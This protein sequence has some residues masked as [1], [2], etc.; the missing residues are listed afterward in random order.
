MLFKILIFT[1][2]HLSKSCIKVREEAVGT[3]LWE[4]NAGLFQALFDIQRF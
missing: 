3:F 2:Y 4:E 1:F